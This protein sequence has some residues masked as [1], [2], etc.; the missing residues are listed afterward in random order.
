MRTREELM[1]LFI[2]VHCAIDREE[3]EPSAE[4]TYEAGPEIRTERWLLQ[5]V[6]TGEWVYEEQ[7]FYDACLGYAN[8]LGLKW[9]IQLSKLRP[10]DMQV[11]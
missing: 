8:E 7:T 5:W 1:R 2:S 11:V 3:R 4:E 10:P 9:P 6:L